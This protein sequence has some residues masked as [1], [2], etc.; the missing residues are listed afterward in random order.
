MAIAIPSLLQPAAVLDRVNRLKVQNTTL[1]RKWGMQSGGNGERTSPFGRRGSYD[2]FNDTRVPMSMTQP[3][4][5]SVAQAPNPV[6]NVPYQIPRNHEHIP[7]LAEVLHNLRPIGGPAGQIDEGG[8]SYISEQ[9]R[10]LKQKATNQREFMVAGMMR[11]SMSW[12]I[13]S[14][15]SN[16]SLAYSGGAVTMDY[17]MPAGNKSQ[18]NMLGAGNIIGTAWDNT[19]APIVSDLLELNAAFIQLTGRGLRWIYTTSTV[20][21]FMLAATQVQNLAGS[22]NQP[23]EY[24]TRNEETEEFTARLRAVPWLP[25]TVSDNGLATGSAQA[26]EK[27]CPDTHIMCGIDA[28][29]ITAQAWHCGEPISRWQGAPTTIINR[30]DFWIAPVWNPTG[31]WLMGLLNFL[32]VLQ[33][34]A[35]LAFIQVDF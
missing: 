11:G 12:T 35:G 29:P 15:F 19:A 28:D 17:Q 13:P 25:I 16:P 23:F 4:A 9:E 1:Q 10:I 31:W 22:V 8:M 3:G 32:P 7:L 6:G 21:Q 26:F 18:A 14:A 20:W 2:V 27:F 33:V 5:P 24:I 34:P 30:E